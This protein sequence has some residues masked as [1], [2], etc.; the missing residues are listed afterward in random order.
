MEDAQC[1]V[2]M[3]E[4]L[5]FALRVAKKSS[6]EYAEE[7]CRRLRVDYMRGGTVTPQRLCMYSLALSQLAALPPHL[8]ARM[9]FSPSNLFASR[10]FKEFR[11]TP[12]Q[13]Q[14]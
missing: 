4:L 1:R 3:A 7:I 2:W 5:E 9:A 14:S 6:S 13:S 8:H 11:P 12:C 10:Y